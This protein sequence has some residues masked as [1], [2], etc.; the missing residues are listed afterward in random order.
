MT[1]KRGGRAAEVDA[2]RIQL[3]KL[4]QEREQAVIRAPIAGVVTAGDVKVG[5][6]LERGKSVAEIAEQRGFRFEAQVPSE[7]V[8]HLAVGLPVRVKVDAFDFQKYGTLPGKV[9]YVAPDS[10]V[11]EGRRGAVYLVRVEVDGDEVGRGDVRARVKLGMAGQAEIVT[12]H[13]SVLSLLVRKV[14]QSIS[15]G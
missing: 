1:T 2:A 15:L 4:G 10:G 11:P 13:E 14:R 12:G 5:D 8:G 9:S 6:I 3:A 7:E